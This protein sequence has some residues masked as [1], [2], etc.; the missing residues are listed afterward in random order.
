MEYLWDE[1]QYSVLQ[2]ACEWFNGLY[3]I[4]DWTFTLSKTQDRADAIRIDAEPKREWGIH[5]QTK[6]I[7]Y[8]GLTDEWEYEH[9]RHVV[10]IG[11]LDRRYKVNEDKDFKELI[12]RFESCCTVSFE[13]VNEQLSQVSAFNTMCVR[14]GFKLA[15]SPCTELIPFELVDCQ[16]YM[17]QVVY[18]LYLPNGDIALDL[19]ING[20]TYEWN[21]DYTLSKFNKRS[22]TKGKESLK[23]LAGAAVI[24]KWLGFTNSLAT[25]DGIVPVVAYAPTD[26]ATDRMA[27]A[28]SRFNR[29]IAGEGH[30][31][32]LSSTM[33]K[34]VVEKGETVAYAYSLL[35]KGRSYG[36]V[37]IDKYGE[38]DFSEISIDRKYLDKVED[39]F[40]FAFDA[41]NDRYQFVRD[42]TKEEA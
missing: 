33:S 27:V 12:K 18:N 30:N 4:Y 40:S 24:W 36:T 19:I 5:S 29:F 22:L 15:A 6:V 32:R 17:K 31:I 25:I 10:Q 2:E 37:Y 11:K 20:D 13:G 26:V 41:V 35:I 28:I 3:N 1:Y 7:L 38:L 39:V 9:D 14:S 8:Y 23:L 21:L 34:D 42:I 16:D